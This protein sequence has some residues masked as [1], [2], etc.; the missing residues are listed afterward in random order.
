[1]AKFHAIDLLKQA[2]KQRYWA[3][4]IRDDSIGPYITQNN[5]LAVAKKIK[6]DLLLFQYHQNRLSCSAH[7]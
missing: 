5:I 1:M 7:P 6:R 4:F 3:L 2:W